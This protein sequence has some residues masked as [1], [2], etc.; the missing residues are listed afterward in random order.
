MNSNNQDSN[1]SNLSL[2]GSGDG[3]YDPLANLF[4]G[5]SDKIGGLKGDNR[6]AYDDL[7]YY[8]RYVIGYNDMYYAG[9]S[10][11]LKKIY[12]ELQYTND[13]LLILGPRGSAKSQSVSI[14][15]TTWMIGHNP[16]V[17]F[18][19]A[20]ASLESQGLAF[21]RQIKQIISQNERYIEI[22]G[23][24]KPPVPEKWTDNEIIVRRNA[25]GGGLK[26]PT[27]GIVGAG[28]AVPSKRADVIVCDDLITMQNAYSETL[29]AQTRRF[30]LQTLFP[31]L[32]PRGRRIVVGSRWDP[33][34]LYYDISKTWGL[35]IPEVPPL[36]LREASF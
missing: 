7:E 29:R 25:P 35:D 31:I 19:L 12:N 28:S 21:G 10:P 17:R 3:P 15:Y 26:D 23:Q 36:N 9:N 27:V 16:L 5:I 4:S 2:G 22:F 34:D 20:F 30:V 14:T 1:L 11:F 13:D 6:A 33:R 18:V 8:S 32:T 24:L